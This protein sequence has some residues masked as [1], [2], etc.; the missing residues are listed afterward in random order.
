MTGYV[1]M[2]R[3]SI[4]RQW[5]DITLEE[6]VSLDDGVVVLCSGSRKSN[7]IVIKSG[8]YVNRYTIFDA[9]HQMEIGHDV[10]IGPHCYFTD[11]DHSYEPD[12]SVRSQPMRY[13]TLIIEDEVWIGANS[14]ILPNVRIGR[15][16]IVAAGAVVKHDVPAMTMVAGIPAKIIR[17]RDIIAS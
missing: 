4:P 5:E 6:N 3:V 9:H 16:A 2:R 7:K 11:A 10:M 17:S 12:R 8:T 14:T 1:W 15:G 13:G